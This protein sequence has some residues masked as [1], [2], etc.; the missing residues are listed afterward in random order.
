MSPHY[1]SY[2]ENLIYEIDLL[3]FKK[4]NGQIRHENCINN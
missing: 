3:D 1:S 2:F 4:N